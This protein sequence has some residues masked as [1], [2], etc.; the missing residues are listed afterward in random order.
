VLL[1]TLIGSHPPRLP[2][3]VLVRMGG[4]FGISEGTVRVALSRMA[5]DGEVEGADG[6]YELTPRLAERQKAFD[7][8]QA[9]A[10]RPWRGEWEVA[11]WPGGVVGAERATLE[12]TCTEALLAPLRDGVWL[13][14]AN[15][16]RTWPRP[17]PAGLT[18]MTAR[19]AAD[20]AALAASLWDID[21]WARTGDLL[22]R[23]IGEERDAA[24][25]FTLATAV[26]RHL[27]TDPVL[28]RSLLPDGWPGPSLRRAYRSYEAELNHLLRATALA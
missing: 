17:A 8:G 1:S 13:R 22:L 20:P 18:R 7:R 10:V 14:P 25:R 16:A 11:V 6:W 23:A 4:V 2:V 15:L 12:A 5:A 9:P 24:R 28:P 27:R 19:P 3:R 21:G 26:L